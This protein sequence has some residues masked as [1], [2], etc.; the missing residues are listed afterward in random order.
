MKTCFLILIWSCLLISTSRALGDVLTISYLNRPPYYYEEDHKASGFLIELQKKI[1]QDAGIEAEFKVRPPK[2]I[3]LEI[4]NPKNHYCSVGWFKKPDRERF[5][6]FTLPI[7]QNEPVVVLTTKQNKHLFSRHTSLKEVFLDNTLTFGGME[8][9]SYGATIDQMI[10]D[11]SPRRYKAFYEQQQLIVMLLRQRISYMLIAPEEIETLIRSAK[12][13]P[14]HFTSI[15]MSDIPL[16][17]KRYLMCSQGVSDE[18]INKINRS[19]V[20]IIG[21]SLPN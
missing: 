2:R 15:Q 6:K 18:L 11:L 12:L 19:I 7:Y 4:K 20:R 21:G 1:L 16:G 13:S 17:N 14:S 10:R 9:F 5:A 8:S 3:M